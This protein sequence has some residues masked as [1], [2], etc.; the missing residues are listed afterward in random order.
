MSEPTVEL[1]AD[2]PVL[3]PGV[4]PRQLPPAGAGRAADPDHR[5]DPFD[6]RVRHVVQV[7]ERG[8]FVVATCVGCGWESFARRSR[9]LARSEGRDHELL[10]EEPADRQPTD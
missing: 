9:P 3:L 5:H 6:P 8:P 4:L 2:R 7:L 10:H 1:P